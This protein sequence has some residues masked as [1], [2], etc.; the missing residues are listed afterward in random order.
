[1]WCESTTALIKKKK[2][3]FLWKKKSIDNIS[4]CLSRLKKKNV[5]NTNTF[6]LLGQKANNSWFAI[7]VFLLKCLRSKNYFYKPSET[8]ETRKATQPP[9]KNY[10]E[11]LLTKAQWNPKA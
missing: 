11:F 9:A 8:V 5:K 4:M 3:P 2:K 7:L 6:V 1:M 10:E